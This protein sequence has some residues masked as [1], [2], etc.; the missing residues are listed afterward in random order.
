MITLNDKSLEFSYMGFF[1]TEN[2]WIHPTTS[3]KT[4][5]LIF[6][7]EGEAHLFEKGK[8]YSLKKGDLILLD[9]NTEHGGFK[10][11][12]GNTNFYWLH[13][14]TENIENLFKKKVYTLDFASTKMIMK[15][16]LHISMKS[17]ELAE[18]YFLKFILELDAKAEYKNP[19][20]YEIFQYIKINNNAPLTVDF[21]S[22]KFGY[23]TDHLSRLIKKEFGLDAK[24]LIIKNRL[25]YIETLLI[26]STYSTKEIATL[27]GFEDENSF[28]KF[29]KYHTKTTPTLYRKKYFLLHL[30]NK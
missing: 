10:K 6:V 2:E 14:H 3:V 13:F 27:S 1:T 7:T 21:L 23:S 20:A 4:Y 18:V 24:S 26:N 19:T 28:L 8:N 16:L 11:S 12:F 22:K 17:K 15:E 29:F 25:E 5:E 30:N 9:K